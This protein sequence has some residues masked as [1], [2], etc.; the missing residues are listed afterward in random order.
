M[1]LLTLRLRLRCWVLN[2]VTQVSVLLRLGI[3]VPRGSI[4][5]LQLCSS[6]HVL[7][8]CGIIGFDAVFSL[9]SRN[10]SL[11]EVA[12]PVLPRCNDFVVEPCGPVNGVC[13]V[14][15]SDVP[16]VENLRGG[17]HILL[18]ILIRLGVLVD[19]ASGM[20]LTA[21]MPVAMLLL[22]CL[23]LCAVVAVRWWL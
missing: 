10:C 2:V 20:L 15:M 6:L 19:R 18:C 12:I 3:S 22:K 8:S 4:G 23:L 16:R 1:I 9:R 14:L 11:C 21:W 13:L 17:R 5:R 7:D